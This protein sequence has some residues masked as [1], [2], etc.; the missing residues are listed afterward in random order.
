MDIRALV[1]MLSNSQDPSE[2]FK[3]LTQI[4][5]AIE[6]LEQGVV[7][8]PDTSL[9][10]RITE[11]ESNVSM[12]QTINDE[13]SSQIKNMET[14]ISL[15]NA[16]NDALKAQIAAANAKDSKQ[17]SQIVA[18]Q[19]QIEDLIVQVADVIHPRD[20]PIETVS[21]SMLEAHVDG[22]APVASAPKTTSV[23]PPVFRIGKNIFKLAEANHDPDTLLRLAKAFAFTKNEKNRGIKIGSMKLGDVISHLFM[24]RA[25][26]SNGKVIPFFRWVDTNKPELTEEG[27][28]LIPWLLASEDHRDI[29]A[30]QALDTFLNTNK[31]YMKV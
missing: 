13:L 10:A 27:I 14:K 4:H 25:N 29:E 31:E 3:L 30:I 23:F 1:F 8:S 12:K 22:V 19:A 11:L 20:T 2:K 21:V 6:K 7:S 28:S 18:F 17:T 15:A 24:F 5:A 16:E 26:K 9:Q